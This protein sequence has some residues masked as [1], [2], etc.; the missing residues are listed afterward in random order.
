ME[1]KGI[2][3]ARWESLSQAK[4]IGGLCFRDFASFN[5]A[6]VAKQGWRIL[7]LPDSLVA[8]ILQARYFKHCHF[9]NA[10]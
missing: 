8:K 5:L 1:K 4:Q 3:W 7:Q 6:L 2:R 9:L 10:K